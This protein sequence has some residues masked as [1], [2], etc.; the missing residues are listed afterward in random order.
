VSRIYRKGVLTVGVDLAAEPAGT[1]LARIEWSAVGAQVRDARVGVDDDAI[2]AAIEQADKVGIDCPLGWPAAFV[3]F[4]SAHHTDHVT[5]PSDVAGKD[6]RRSLAYRRTDEAVRQ[7]IGRWPL[8]VAAD[9]IGYTA[10]RAAALLAS[11]DRD[12]RPV[13]RGGAGVVVEVYPAASL[14]TWGLPHRGYKGNQNLPQLA[15]LVDRITH[16]AD[17]LDFGTHETLCRVSDHAIDAV[18][19]A[20]TARAAALGLTT[21]PGPDQLDVARAEGW[22]ALPTSSL[23]E[24]RSR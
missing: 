5:S 7:A 14:Y 15:D 13:D 18:I 19:A 24:L 16:A 3:E 20:L 4:V 9:R 6:W 2:L 8:S 12:G 17:W 22:I 1:A 23:T 21:Q 11:L 10:M